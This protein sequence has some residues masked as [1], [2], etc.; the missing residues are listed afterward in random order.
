MKKNTIAIGPE[1]REIQMF[2][3]PFLRAQAEF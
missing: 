2:W 1:M 3:K